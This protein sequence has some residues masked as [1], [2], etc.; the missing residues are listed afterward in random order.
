MYALGA[1]VL[2][3]GAA[4]GVLVFNLVLDFGVLLITVA[5][6]LGWHSERSFGGGWAALLLACGLFA[7]LGLQ[8]IA[9]PDCG[10]IGQ[11]ASGPPA[12][13]AN[14]ESRTYTVFAL[15]GVA[16]AVLLAER[17]RQGRLRRGPQR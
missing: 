4:H 5:A 12:C 14:S 1:L 9:L 2:A 13:L 7:V 8:T 11:L 16:V 15:F 10:A 3:Y 17:D 6:A